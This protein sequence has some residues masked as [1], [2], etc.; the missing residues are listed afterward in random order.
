M[1]VVGSLTLRRVTRHAF[2]GGRRVPST[3]STEYIQAD[4]RRDEHSGFVGYRL[5]PNGRDIYRQTPRTA[6]IKR[7]DLQKTFLIN[8]D[9]RQFTEWPVVPVPTVHDLQVGA[10]ACPP[11]DAPAPTMRV[12]TE[13]VDTGE[14]K[15]IF[16][17]SA[18]HMITRQRIIPLSGSARA[19]R[20]T[21]I[22]G[23]Y[24]D[25]DTRLTCEPWADTGHGF[26]L[27]YKHGEQP[28][29][30]T[31]VN[32]G[33]PERGY[34]VRL[35][36]TEGDSLFEMDVAELSTFALDPSLFEVPA[37][38]ARVEMIRQEPAT[39]LA[40]RLKQVYDRLKRRHVFF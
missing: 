27:G 31:F 37:G 13:T 19:E 11:A 25:L 29:R 32:I 36:T 23:W 21:V 6:L 16:G 14:R 24:I 20:V 3:E 30:P 34:A 38:F 26:A 7:C 2:S 10:E 9:D 22:D 18:R 35:R 4:R 28:P 5:W 15:E 39:P 12:E 1:A 33:E 8:F 40:V 17:R